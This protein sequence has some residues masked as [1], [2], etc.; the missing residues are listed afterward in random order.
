M[1]FCT[2]F[3]EDLRELKN[4]ASAASHVA[5]LDQMRRRLA[6]LRAANGGPYSRSLPIVQKKKKERKVRAVDHWLAPR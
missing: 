6:E 3:K 1:S 4:L 5:V 2:I